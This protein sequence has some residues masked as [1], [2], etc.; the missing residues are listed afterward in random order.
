M[1]D[2]AHIRLNNG[3]GDVEVRCKVT[4]AILQLSEL[5]VTSYFVTKL[6]NT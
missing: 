2:F 6:R 4:A 3:E 5:R 1:L